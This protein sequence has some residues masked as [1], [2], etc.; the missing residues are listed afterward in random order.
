MPHAGS[1]DAELYYFALYFSLLSKYY[2]ESAVY[3]AKHSLQSIEYI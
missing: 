1:A 2:T 3:K